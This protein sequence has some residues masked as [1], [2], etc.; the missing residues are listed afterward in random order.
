MS[1]KA[2]PPKRRYIISIPPLWA[3]LVLYVALQLVLA[4]SSPSKWIVPWSAATQLIALLTVPLLFGSGTV[5]PHGVISNRMIFSSNVAS[6][7]YIVEVTIMRFAR[8]SDITLAELM[9]P[10]SMGYA[11]SFMVIRSLCFPN[12]Y[13][14]SA[15][16]VLCVATPLVE[17]LAV[18]SVA[19]QSPVRASLLFIPSI[20]TVFTLVLSA[21][22][23]IRRGK[24]VLKEDPTVILPA[25]LEAWRG[26]NTTSIER[27]LEGK[28]ERARLSNYLLYFRSIDSNAAQ[29]IWAIL[30]AHPGPFNPLGSYNLPSQVYSYLK[31][32][33]GN[34][35]TCVFHGPSTHEF[36]LVSAREVMKYLQGLTQTQPD[37][38][39]SGISRAELLVK[40]AESAFP[41]LLWLGKDL[42][43]FTGRA[44]DPYSDDVAPDLI[45][46]L[47]DALRLGHAKCVVI[48]V[49]NGIT[50]LSNGE[51]RLSSMGSELNN[52]I[53]T[54][55]G[56]R[57][58]SLVAGFA[59]VAKNQLLDVIEVGPA[60]V[61][62]TYLSNGQQALGVVVFDANSIV[63]TV[64]RSLTKLCSERLGYPILLCTTDNHITASDVTSRHGY[65]K[66]AQVTGVERLADIILGGM[67]TAQAKAGR[68]VVDLHEI[69]TESLVLG[70]LLNAISEL[71]EFA[72]RVVPRGLLLS[73]ALHVVAFAGSLL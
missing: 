41:S 37:Y 31:R 68:V 59:E 48:D 45:G 12:G 18:G 5:V 36:D 19:G 58:E 56:P 55:E 21:H 24:A 7:I 43:L 46:A 1:W 73:L 65:L 47:R 3:N 27:W 28:A 50:S 35:P 25:L 26:R 30:G 72:S 14:A 53:R 71:T 40:D 34:V 66:L 10:L 62:F 20:S 69:H 42:V 23:V 9:V 4:F 13:L 29:G 57:Q 15:L 67:L 61:C 49:H 70:N 33:L 17:G 63:P 6:V 51:E 16:S 32:A 2:L 38:I 52:L 11:F 8:G 39:S 54:N 44:L 22:A 64:A 60:G